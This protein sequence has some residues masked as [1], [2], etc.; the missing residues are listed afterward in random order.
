MLQHSGCAGMAALRSL[1]LRAAWLVAIMAPPARWPGYG[2][3]R[4]APPPARARLFRLAVVGSVV[5][6][7][8]RLTEGGARAAVQKRW[9]EIAPDHR[10][11][12]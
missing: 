7:V 9:N 11:K 8:E 6:R 2:G 3:R 10:Q 1:A 4:A 5:E 12:Y